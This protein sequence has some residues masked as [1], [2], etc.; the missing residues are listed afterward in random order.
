[1][2]SD[3]SM[4]RVVAGNGVATD[5]PSV[6]S[7]GFLVQASVPLGDSG[8]R[9]YA[10]FTYVT[11]TQ[12][13]VQ[14]HGVGPLGFTIDSANQNSAVGEVGLLWEPVFNTSGGVV[15]RPA[16][17]AGV[18]DNAGDRGQVISGSLA[19]LT[20]T[21]FD[22]DGARLWGVAGVVDASL[23]IRLNQSLELFGDVRGRF[24][25]H[26]TDSLASVGGVFRF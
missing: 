24:G 20:G 15:V 6:D 11:S 4:S 21:A 18:Q 26:Q 1:M 13:G 5:A 8:L 10:R 19:G 2:R 17:R 23:K 25:D 7:G 14:E 9:P 12:N 16:L 3:W 22:Q